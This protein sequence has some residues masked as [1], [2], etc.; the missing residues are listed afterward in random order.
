MT[1]ICMNDAKID[2]IPDVVMR[3]YDE[4]THVGGSSVGH[5][6]GPANRFLTP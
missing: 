1:C 3:V 5:G 4:L 6:C 2:S